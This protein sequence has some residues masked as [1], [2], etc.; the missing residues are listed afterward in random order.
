MTISTEMT[1]EQA[2]QHAKHQANTL[3]GTP[4]GDQH[5]QLSFWLSELLT[6]REAQPFLFAICNPDGSAWLDENCVADTAKNLKPVLNDLCRDTG[7]A[8]R[9]IPLFSAPQAAARAES[10]DEWLSK[11]HAPI[12][13]DCGMVGVEVMHHWM[14]EAYKAGPSVSAVL[15][16]FSWIEAEKITDSLDTEIRNLI[17]DPTADN[18]VCFVRSVL[19]AYRAAWLRDRPNGK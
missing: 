14:R 12:D 11:Q 15:D 18:A 5:K 1:L 13:V 19:E 3:T 16:Q 9:I 6:A 7:D 10:F 4:C 17:D 8:Y 2:I